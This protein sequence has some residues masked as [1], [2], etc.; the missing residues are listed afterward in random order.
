MKTR[1]IERAGSL[2]ILLM[3][4]VLLWGESRR[5]LRPQTQSKRT[6]DLRNVEIAVI[7]AIGVAF[8]EVPTVRRLA[9]LVERRAW[10]IRRL[11]LAEWA[12]IVLAVLLMDYTL[13][14]WHVA[15]HRWKFL[16]RF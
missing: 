5:P 16:W 7:S 9:S 14:L 1:N 3:M 2:L 11:R 10:G 4:G 6:R 8:V 13:Y 15:I 12:E